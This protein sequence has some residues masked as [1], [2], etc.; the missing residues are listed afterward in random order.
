LHEIDL[1]IDSSQLVEREYDRE[2]RDESWFT[3]MLKLL[4]VE[5]DWSDTFYF[6]GSTESKRAFNIV[7]WYNSS[8]FVDV[9]KDCFRLILSQSKVDDIL[10]AGAKPSVGVDS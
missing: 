8:C 2:K 3:F 6:L 9:N 10:W 5:L 7:R 1:L 4:R